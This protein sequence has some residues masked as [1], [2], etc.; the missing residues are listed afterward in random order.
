VVLQRFSRSRRDLKASKAFVKT[1]SRAHWRVSVPR[2]LLWGFIAAC[3]LVRFLRR[4][5]RDRT[6]SVGCYRYRG[7]ALLLAWGFV[8]EPHC[9]FHSVRAAD[10]SGWGAVRPGCPDV[11]VARNDSV[12]TGFAVRADDGWHGDP[13][14]ARSAQRVSATT[15]ASV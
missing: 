8:D 5:D 6:V 14:A 9:R 11:H 7:R 3:A 2:L 10:D 4:V 12:V 13:R 1:A 15:V